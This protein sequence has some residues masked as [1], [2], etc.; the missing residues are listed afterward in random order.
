[1]SVRASRHSSSAA[2]RAVVACLASCG[3]HQP[4]AIT[5]CLMC[6]SFIFGSCPKHIACWL[7]QP[8][9]DLIV[10]SRESPTL[11]SPRLAGP[12]PAKRL[13]PPHC[14]TSPNAQNDAHPLHPHP[15]ALVLR[16]PWA[17]SLQSL[18]SKSKAR[19]V[20]LYFE[21]QFEK[22]PASLDSALD[23]HLLAQTLSSRSITSKSRIAG[24]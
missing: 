15:P 12:L 22:N 19:P 6:H 14:L 13:R 11:P 9:V 18:D 16:S 5:S 7:T 24:R 8:Q 1:M 10:A 17:Q 4:H 20:K 3:D 23:Q 21:E 2:S